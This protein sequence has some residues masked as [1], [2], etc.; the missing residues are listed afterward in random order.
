MLASVRA[1]DRKGEEKRKIELGVAQ[2]QHGHGAH[3]R[4]ERRGGRSVAGGRQLGYE[5]ERREG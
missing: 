3:G 1:A 2:Q 5:K 4:S